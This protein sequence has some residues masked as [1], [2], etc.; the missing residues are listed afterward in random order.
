M[1]PFVGEIRCFGFGK[2]PQGWLPCNGQILPVAQN[3]ALASLLGKAYGGDGVTTFGLPDL[4]GVAPIHF[5]PM[6]T[7]PNQNT[8]VGGKGGV[9]SVT[10]ALTQIPGHN[11]Q[12]AASNNAATVISPEN[13][14]PAAL[15]APHLA[16]AASTSPLT[17][18]AQDFI[19]SVGDG[20][21]HTNMQPYI[22]VNYCIAT[23][24]YYPSRP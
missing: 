23:V 22:V 13:N 20:Q 17:A 2:I 6:P 3:A 4:R 14:Y 11:H 1:D 15:P 9:E 16:Y 19:S 24:G 5:N 18:M 12:V 8:N 10:L 7:G 21:A